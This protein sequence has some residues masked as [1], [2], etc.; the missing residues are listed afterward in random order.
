MIAVI[1]FLVF[2]IG[3]LGALLLMVPGSRYDDDVG[4]DDDEPWDGGAP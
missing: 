4:A 1:I 2:L 3:T